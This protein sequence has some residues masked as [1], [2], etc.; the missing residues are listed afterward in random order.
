MQNKRRI[1]IVGSTGSIGCNAYKLLKTTLH[2][3]FIVEFL[4]CNN[5]FEEILTQINTLKPK[6]VCVGSE[7]Y[8]SVKENVS[9][10]EVFDDISKLL[11]AYK[12]D[13]TLYALSG[14]IGIEYVLE[15]IRNTKNL[16]IANKE[17]IVSAWQFIEEESIKHGTQ[18]IPVD[19]EHNSLYRLLEA[20]DSTMIKSVAI[21]A[22]GGPFF[23][24]KYADLQNITPQ[25]AMKHPNWRM[26]I[27]NTIDSATMA[28][29][30]LELIEA[31]HLFGYTQEKIDVYINRQSITHASV[32]LK[33]GGVVSFSSTPDM[34]SHIGH[35]IMY[36][37]YTENSDISPQNLVLKFNAIKPDE[38]PIFF[39]GREIAKKSS[40]YH[41]VFNIANE[42]AVNKFVQ[43]KI[44]YT[45]ILPFIQNACDKNKHT[46]PQNIAECLQICADLRK[47]LE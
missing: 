7:I 46:E 42:V 15:A 28:N 21:T 10:V 4:V 23:K 37:E 1:G 33:S 44:K 9:D 8:K 40:V 29:K 36:P 20:F 43:G 22:S 19:S 31:M 34:K 30:V 25:D 24:K 14:T 12:T 16:A 32:V 6:A 41:T 2:D 3:K 26:G 5:N 45:E 11:Q 27:K 35:A 17:A 13:V 38:F 47:E 39:L 18:I